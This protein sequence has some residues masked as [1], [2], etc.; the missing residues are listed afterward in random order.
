MPQ[1]TALVFGSQGQ[2]GSLMCK[3]LL[4]QN[5][6][7]I[8]LTR[9]NNRKS[10]NHSLLGIDKKAITIV[11][12]DIKDSKIVRKLIENFKPCE[13]YNLAAQS[14]VGKSFK[15]PQNTISSIVEGTINILEVCKSIDF[16]GNIFFAGSSEIFGH[17]E[18]PASLQHSQDPKSPYAIGKQS[19]F[20]LVKI[21]RDIYNL[22]CV[23]GIL[24]NHESPLRQTY[25]VTHKIISG[26]IQCLHNKSHIIELG[27]IDIERDW[28]WAEEY[29]D[30]M[31]L[32]NRSN[33][34]KDQ[35][36]CTGKLTKLMRFIEITF[37]KLN[38]NWEDHIRTNQINIR[39][40]DILKSYGNPKQMKIDTG[41][42]AKI[43]IE[44]LIEKL[45]ESKIS[46]SKPH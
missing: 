39:S 4:R 35:I 32:M 11:K 16:E 23:T 29:I 28:G 12:G 45:I 6:K 24:F 26:A 41:W 5:Y 20:N 10:S 30:A 37:K 18:R 43:D 21:Y 1:K 22:N 15:D 42:E 25:F 13:I 2:D 9:R 19:S 44:E 31:Q 33:K 34:H 14:S 3:S 8:G 40:N 17:T 7:V 27:N 38:L 36:I 46:K